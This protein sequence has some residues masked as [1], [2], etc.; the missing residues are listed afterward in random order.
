MGELN[1]TVK[2]NIINVVLTNCC[3]SVGIGIFSR[4]CDF[5]LGCNM[6]APSSRFSLKCYHMV[7]RNYYAEML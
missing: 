4:I 6:K 5:C 2:R 1:L 3:I 7:L